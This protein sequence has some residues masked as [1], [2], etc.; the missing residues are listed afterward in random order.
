MRSHRLPTRIHEYGRR[1]TLRI[2]VVFN[3]DVDDRPEPGS[4]V[5][6]ELRDTSLAD[7]PS[8]TVEAADAVTVPDPGPLLA[9]VEVQPFQPALTVWAPADADGDGRVSVGDLV[10]MASFL[11]PSPEQTPALITVTVRQVR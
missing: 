1:M 7:A 8:V 5:V 3:P 6:V 4:R 9:T 11:V 2:D 10:T